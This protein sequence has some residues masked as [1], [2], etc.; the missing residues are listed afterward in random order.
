[1]KILLNIIALSLLFVYGHGQT[2]ELVDTNLGNNA[3]VMVSYNNKIYYDGSDSVHGTELWVTD[4]TK[5]G[6]HMVK[7]M[8]PNGSSNPFGEVLFNGKLY[9]QAADSSGV[10][11]LWVSDG[12]DTGTQMVYAFP[13]VV[14]QPGPFG[15]TPYKSK[16]YFAAVDNVNG[17]G[18]WAT[19]GT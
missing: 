5:Q 17:N 7:D 10:N 15:F 3:G 9:F 8:N 4:G 11:C 18:L 14:D 1:M 6:T 12:T 13:G 16:L 2:F 19:D